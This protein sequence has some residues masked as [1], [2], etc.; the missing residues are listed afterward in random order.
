MEVS[1]DMNDIAFEAQ[2]CYSLGNTHT[3]MQNH[4]K[5]AEF[6]QLHLSFAIQLQ[7]R[8]VWDWVM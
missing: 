5:A 4:L 2:A 1:R 8:W 6:H 7:D 3:L